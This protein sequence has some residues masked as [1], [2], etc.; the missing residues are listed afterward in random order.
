MISE[1]EVRRIAALAK[2]ALDA[3]ELARMQRDLGAILDFVDQIRSIDVPGAAEAERA[4]ASTP[5]RADGP[6]PSLDQADVAANAPRFLA[7]HFVVPR[8]LGG[9][10]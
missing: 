7:G 3:G 8:I 10:S 2:L 1:D 5:L 6:L 4:A 9:E